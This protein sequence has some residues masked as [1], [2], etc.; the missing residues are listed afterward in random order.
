MTYQEYEATNVL[1]FAIKVYPGSIKKIN[2]WKMIFI[3]M[4]LD[5]T[6]SGE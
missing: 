3:V 5:V 2:P 6:G 4:D 1:H